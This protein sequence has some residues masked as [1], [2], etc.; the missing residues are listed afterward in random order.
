[1]KKLFLFIS[2][3]FAFNAKADYWTPKA[4]YPGAGK[5]L[6]ISFSIGDYGYAGCGANA[7]DF[8]R[9]DPA[10]D[11][12]TQEATV[13]GATARRAGIGFSINDKGYAGTGD[14]GI[15]Y[16]NDWWEY[17]PSVDQWLQKADAGNSGRAG[18]VQ[19]TLGTKGYLGTGMDPNHIM[20]KDLWE[21]SPDSGIGI[22]ETFPEQIHITPNPFTNNITITSSYFNNLKFLITI[23]DDNGEIVCK[24]KINKSEE[25]I[26]LHNLRTG[27]YFMHITTDKF[28]FSKKIV[29]V[30]F[31]N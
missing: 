13:P 31:Q 21:Y 10:T 18:A 8:W 23:Y 27:I 19:F 17:N 24:N 2:L 20:T 6:P 3:G 16:R 11:S 4:A 15:S 28:E 9:Y 1:M 12:W 25:N 30:K 22:T 26:D 5:E 7:N 29:K 14:D